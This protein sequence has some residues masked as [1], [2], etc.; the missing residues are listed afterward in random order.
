VSVL[1]L[2]HLAVRFSSARGSAEAVRDVSFELEEGATL[3]LVGESGSGKSATALALLGLLPPNAQVEAG[4]AR[5]EGRDLFA[6]SAR[7]LRAVRGRRIALVFQDPRAAVDP[8]TT[9]GRQLADVLDVHLGLRRREARARAAH[10]L[11]EVG[12]PDPERRLDS[13]PHE[14]SGGQRQ[15]VMLAMALLCDPRVLIADE[16][17]T[18]LDATLQAQVLEL[19]ATLQKTHGTAVLLIT[20]D[21]GVVARACERVAVL[22]AGRVVEEGPVGEL[23]RAPLHP[24]TRALLDSL[25]RLGL[26]RE[27]RPIP[28]APPDPLERE[29]GCAFAPRCALAS[30][31]CL[32]ELPPFEVFRRSTPG[33]GMTVSGDRR[34]ACFEKLRMANAAAPQVSRP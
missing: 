14:L 2:E 17:T 8:F 32:A 26:E 9:I 12:L 13:Y 30:A 29:A 11:A 34:A 6:L 25:P 24:Y 18:A 7:E 5:F 27:L 1:E 21:L 23:F 10:A 4:S 22:Y 33:A 19:I 31:R 3:G 16:P 20:H 15:R 28:G